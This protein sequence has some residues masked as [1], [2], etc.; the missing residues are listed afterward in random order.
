MWAAQCR[1]SN[2]A[3]RGER[4][5][6]AAHDEVAAQRQPSTP[7]DDD[8]GRNHG[9]ATHSDVG[10]P[11]ATFDGTRR[12]GR[13][14]HDVRA[15]RNDVGCLT[16]TFDLKLTTRGVEHGSR[17]THN[18]VGRPSPAFDSTR[19][20]GR[21]DHHVRAAHDNVG[22]STRTFDSE[23][24]QMVTMLRRYRSLG[25]QWSRASWL[26]SK[27]SFFCYCTDT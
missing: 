11:T 23:R 8:G 13:G 26:C 20:R 22:C 3:R 5:G 12:Q 14:N 7:L 6:K 10:C 17:A 21:G 25:E 24:R 2:H 4:C 15:A 19:R 16:L 1:S 18:D 27:C 9:M